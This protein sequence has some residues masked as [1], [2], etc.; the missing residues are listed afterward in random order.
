[1]NI[2]D[3]SFPYSDDVELHGGWLYLGDQILCK[4]E[5]YVLLSDAEE[6]NREL[7]DKVIVILKGIDECESE[8]DHGYWET[9]GGAKFGKK[10]LNKIKKLKP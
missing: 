6:F 9:S 10:I 5:R 4:G 3:K 2:V 8:T 1:M 7:I